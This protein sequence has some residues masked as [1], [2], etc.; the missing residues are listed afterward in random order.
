MQMAWRHRAAQRAAT[1]HAPP[2][3]CGDDSGMGSP[4][5]TGRL[6]RAVAVAAAVAISG[7]AVANAQEQGQGAADASAAGASALAGASAAAA[8]ASALGGTAGDG[9]TTPDIPPLPVPQCAPAQT[10]VVAGMPIV[11]PCPGVTFPGGGAA[12]T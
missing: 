5:T 4:A 10:L 2:P 7:V 1:T 3:R 9:A 6:V 8:Y 12:T 11:I